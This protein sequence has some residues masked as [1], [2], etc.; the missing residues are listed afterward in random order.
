M[1][2]NGYCWWPSRSL[3]SWFW[4]SQSVQRSAL[5]CIYEFW[6][7][8]YSWASFNVYHYHTLSRQLRPV[9]NPRKQC[10]SWLSGS[11]GGTQ[12][13]AEV[14]WYYRWCWLNSFCHRYLGSLGRAG[15][16][17]DIQDWSTSDINHALQPFFA[18]VSRWLW[19]VE[20]PNAFWG[21]SS[22]PIVVM[23]NNNDRNNL[24]YWNNN[25]IATLPSEL[26]RTMS[27]VSFGYVFS[28]LCYNN[29]KNNNWDI[30]DRSSREV[31]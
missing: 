24:I 8:F 9:C 23:F 6:H 28:V 2:N 27:S 18:N 10:T 13:I 20:T 22:H 17:V 14:C 3:L 7:A 11:K 26:Y 1:R 19:G 21:H 12:L 5:P 16:G 15:L 4:S 30:E 29:N 25:I 31:T